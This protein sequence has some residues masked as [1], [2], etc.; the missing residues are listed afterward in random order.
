MEYAG[1]QVEIFDGVS[2]VDRRPDGGR[3]SES[4]KLAPIFGGGQPH[5]MGS[6]YPECRVC[7]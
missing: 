3:Q 2:P 6:S 4:W 5:H 7:I 1:D